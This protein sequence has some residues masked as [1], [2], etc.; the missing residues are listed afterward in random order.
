MCCD[1]DCS[2]KCHFLRNFWN[3]SAFLVVVL[4]NVPFKCRLHSQIILS[5]SL[6]LPLSLSLLQCSQ[7][8]SRQS[9]RGR[10][11]GLSLRA[12]RDLWPAASGRVRRQGRLGAEAKHRGAQGRR[13]ER[14]AGGVGRGRQPQGGDPLLRPRRNGAW[15]SKCSM[16]TSGVRAGRVQAAL[17]LRAA[18]RPGHLVRSGQAADAQRHLRPHHQ[19]L[20]LLP[21]RR[22]GLAGRSCPSEPEWPSV[23]D[24]LTVVIFV[25]FCNPVILM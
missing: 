3:K 2:E 21:H 11:V 4:L 25:F 8:L 5:L 1:V 19:T 16:L 23:R 18:D 22:Q 15:C 13:R 7:L 24:C 6:P 9:A 20:S 17:L 10:L 12:Q 14:A